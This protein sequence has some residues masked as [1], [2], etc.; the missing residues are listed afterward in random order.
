M[1]YD[2]KGKIR[3]PNPN[4]GLY[5]VQIDIAVTPVNQRAPQRVASERMTTHQERTWYGAD[6]GL[7]EAVHL[8][9]CDYNPPSPLGPM[10][11]T[12]STTRANIGDMAG[13]PRSPVGEPA[14][15]FGKVLH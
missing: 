11:S 9:Y 4:L 15:P 7:E 8:H 3:L 14:F 1:L 12:C 10:G 13:E 6:P 2:N 5:V